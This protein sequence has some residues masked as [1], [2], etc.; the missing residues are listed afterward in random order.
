M[1]GKLRKVRRR[2]NWI[3]KV[4]INGMPNNESDFFFNQT[5]RTW[6]NLHLMTQFPPLLLFSCQKHCWSEHTETLHSCCF[7]SEC[8]SW[9]TGEQVRHELRSTC[10]LEGIPS[11]KRLL[12]HINAASKKSFLQVHFLFYVV[13]KS[14]LILQMPVCRCW[15]LIF[16]S[17]LSLNA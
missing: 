13:L 1:V 6:A 8:R 10:A 7:G 2:I 17:S 3:F 9:N 5:N 11:F 14:R 12:C 15:L 16:V 4:M